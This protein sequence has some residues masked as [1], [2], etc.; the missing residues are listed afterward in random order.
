M[1]FRSARLRL[2]GSGSQLNIARAKGKSVQSRRCPAAV[3]GS[4]PHHVWRGDAVS[5]NAFAT[6]ERLHTVEVYR[7]G[8]WTHPCAVRHVPF[9][10]PLVKGTERCV[11]VPRTAPA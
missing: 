6:S 8:V 7:V 5:R 10:G 11:H 9:L 3:I 1:S 4:H 2:P